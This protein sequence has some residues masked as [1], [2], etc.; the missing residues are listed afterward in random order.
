MYKHFLKIII[1][2]YSIFGN[3]NKV[4]GR[5]N[6]EEVFI[7]QHEDLNNEEQL[8]LQ[9]EF[10][11]DDYIDFEDERQQQSYYHPYPYPRP[12]PRPRPRPPYYYPPYY[13][14]YYY[15]PYYPYYPWYGYGG[16]GYGGG[17]YGGGGY[18]GGHGGGYN[19]EY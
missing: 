10:I 15:P 16:G 13:P 19:R 9:Q 2:T 8:S 11:D 6:F 12:R 5:K 7:L 3:L 18:G 4:K 14:P 17:G 1:C